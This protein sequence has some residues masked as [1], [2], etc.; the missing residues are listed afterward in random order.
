MFLGVSSARSE[1]YFDADSDSEKRIKKV[2]GGILAYILRF[3][4]LKQP[5]LK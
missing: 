4:K 2:F 3:L 5:L 1:L